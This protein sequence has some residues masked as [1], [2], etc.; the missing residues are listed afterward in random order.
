[1]ENA[2]KNTL[3]KS[4][5]GYFKYVTND[6]RLWATLVYIFVSAF[7]ISQMFPKDIKVSLTIQA[8]TRNKWGKVLDLLKEFKPVYYIS[9]FYEQKSGEEK[10]VYMVN[11]LL[12][13]W[14]YYLIQQD[15]KSI[16]V[17]AS[18]SELG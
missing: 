1:L 10:T 13:K 9:H 15:L 4:P 5:T 3:E 11:C 12:T 16:G 6:E 18:I 17:I 7:L 8:D 2:E 14:G